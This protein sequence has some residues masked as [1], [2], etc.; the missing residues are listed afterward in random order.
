MVFNKNI[1]FLILL[2]SK[3]FVYS[4]IIKIPF[5]ILKYERNNQNLEKAV[6]DMA[7]YYKLYSTIEIGNPPQNI[8]TTFFLKSSNF[9]IS[10]LC[11][12]STSFYSYKNSNSFKRIETDNKPIGFGNQIYGNESLY[13]YEGIT[14]RKILIENLLIYLPELDDNDN[15][16]N[17]KN[18]NC[19]NIGMKFPDFSNNF[20]KTFIEQLKRKNIIN[21]YMW[22]LSFYNN[23]YHKDYDGAFIFGD[24]LND[25]YPKIYKDDYDLNKLTYIYTGSKRKK[26]EEKKNILEWSLYFDKIYYELSDNLNGT[27]NLNNIVNL[28]KAIP[29]FDFN[30][31]IILS[32][33]EYFRNIQRD[34][35]NYY[36]NKNICKYSFMRG[37]MYKFIYCHYRNFT[38]KDLE[39][40]PILKF[41]NI[42][43]RYIFSLD[44]KD[45]FSLT[46]DKKYYI[47]N[48]LVA[49]VYQGD[50]NE[51]A[52]YWVFGLPFW[53]KYQFSFDTDKKL[54]YFYNEKN[55]FLDENEFDLDESEDI[56]ES[57]IS[58]DFNDILSDVDKNYENNTIIEND[59]MISNKN[60][61]DIKS[62]NIVIKKIFL[63]FGIVIIFFCLLFCILLLI[64]KILF[65]KG[66][67]LVRL[68]KANE[69]NDDYD[70]SNKNI[71]FINE[72]NNAKN[73]ECEMQI[74]K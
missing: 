22:I 66:F 3:Y 73:Q 41:K 29:E 69:L 34:Y 44:Y 9:Y 5:K 24:I 62:I 1:I 48:I 35:F 11:L 59:H 8:E 57:E 68:K 2:I 45:L 53:K 61:K 58:S 42:A 71:N 33:F 43:L 54:I 20:Q 37:S 56:D 7:F 31:N 38:Q 6:E 28:H 50:N 13:L 17:N 46:Y 15:L 51:N 36:Y 64:K 25:Y 19:L 10:N 52:G 26:F 32:T 55:I 49:N 39:K 47:F 67:T 16:N 27:D 40:F 70:Y 14:N 21:Q 30:M 18:R 4:S 65:I 12:N 74:K 23:K 72:N 60:K 63:F